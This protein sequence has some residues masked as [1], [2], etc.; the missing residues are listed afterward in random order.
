MQRLSSTIRTFGIA[1]A[2]IAL[3]MIA[4]IFA[5]FPLLKSGLP[6]RVA[7]FR[8]NSLAAEYPLDHDIIFAVKGKNGP[9]D[10]E[11][12]NKEARIV[13]VNCP[14]QICRRSGSI[15]GTFG[16]LVCA[17]NNILIEI[18]SAKAAKSVD[19]VTY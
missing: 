15:S 17:P 18:R 9:V 19:G 5:A 8:D 12:K 1:D 16:Q 6:D 10:I 11:I 3:V 4:G 14:H 2:F 13:H 7:V